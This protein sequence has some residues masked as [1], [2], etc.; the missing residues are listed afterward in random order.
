MKYYYI[1]IELSYNEQDKCITYPTKIL[2][3]GQ[4]RSW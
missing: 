1:S 4:D 3:G 2:D